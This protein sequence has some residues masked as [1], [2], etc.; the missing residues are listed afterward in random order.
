[1]KRDLCIVY[2]GKLYLI[3]NIM[4]NCSHSLRGLCGLKYASI[5]EKGTAVGV[6]VCED[7]VDWNSMAWVMLYVL[8]SHSL[9]GLCGLKFC[10]I[11]LIQEVDPVT[12]CEDCVDWNVKSTGVPTTLLC[13]SLRGL[14]GLKYH[15]AEDCGRGGK[16]HSLRGLCG[17]KSLRTWVWEHRYQSQS[18]RT[19][20]IEIFGR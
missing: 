20:W 5:N 4:H 8:Q 13:H 3:V 19:V 6:P 2:E 11:H 18:A 7:C 9:R 1:M 10:I 12:V 16:G 17:L 14:C 15:Y